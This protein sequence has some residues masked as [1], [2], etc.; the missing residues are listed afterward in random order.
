MHGIP[1][2]TTDAMAGSAGDTSTRNWRLTTE[3]MTRN[4]KIQATSEPEG[5]GKS[6]SWSKT[7]Q[8]TDNEDIDE[9][10]R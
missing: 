7:I 10:P 8:T 5:A 4:T 9:S 6:V 3:Y 1:T 2:V